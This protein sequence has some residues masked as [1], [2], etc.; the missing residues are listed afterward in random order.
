MAEG[1]HFALQQKAKRWQRLLVNTTSD[2]GVARREAGGWSNG[3]L[4]DLPNLR[5]LNVYQSGRDLYTRDL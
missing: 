4:S 5:D 1:K 2:V 3:K